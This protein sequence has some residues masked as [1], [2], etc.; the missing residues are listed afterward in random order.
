MTVRPYAAGDLDAVLDVWYRASLIAHPFLT[1]EFFER[2]RREI[3]ERW[4]PAADTIVAELDGRVVG[5]LS[6]I[7]DEVGAIFV[8][9][10]S[11]GA[12][13]GRTLMDTAAEQHPVLELDVFEENAI[14]RRFYDTY[15]FETVG[16]HMNDELGHWELRLRLN[17]HTVDPR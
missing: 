15:G 10:E 12:G 11:Q 13:V 17:T 1:E 14:G 7:D 3:A 6:L 9:P 5:F 4:M 2:E 8:A 16:R